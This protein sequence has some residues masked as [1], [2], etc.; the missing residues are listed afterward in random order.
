MIGGDTK[1]GVFSVAVV[2]VGESVQ[3]SDPLNR[4]VS[5]ARQEYGPHALS[6]I[7]II[8]ESGNTNAHLCAKA[9]ST[10]YSRGHI[11]ARTS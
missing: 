6:Q 2:D 11:G 10:P 1:V 5:S 7:I 9:M 4:T 8:E 3:Q